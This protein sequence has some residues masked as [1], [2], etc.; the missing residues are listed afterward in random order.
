MKYF[1]IY[2]TYVVFIGLI[3][4][5]AYL[6]SL[7]WD[8]VVWGSSKRDG[9]FFL[10]YYIAILPMFLVTSIVK[11]YFLKNESSI[12]LKNSFFLYTI[13][14]TTPALD[15]HGSQV[16]LALGVVFC[17]IVCICILFEIVKY[18]GQSPKL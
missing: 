15:T 2:L 1:K 7:R 16:A 17:I 4:Y 6:Y 3:T 13:L 11:R 10:L 14:V 9:L 18:K 5:T 12:Y 8:F